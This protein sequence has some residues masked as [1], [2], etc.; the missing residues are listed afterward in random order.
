MAARNKVALTGIERQTADI[1]DQAA[2][3]R[4]IRDFAPSV[5]VN[6]AGYT[7]VDKAE[8]EPELAMR[9][10]AE[11]PAVRRRGVHRGR[12]PAH[13]YFHRLRFR[14]P[15][16][17]PL[18]GGRPGSTSRRLRPQQGRGRRG[19]ARRLLRA[20]HH[21]HRL[22]VRRLW[23]QFLEDDPAAGGASE[24]SSTL[25]PTNTARRPAT[26]DLANAILAAVAAIA[27]GHTVWGTYHFAGAGETT[28]YGFASRIVAAQAEFTGRRPRVN[29]VPTS[30][31]PTAARRPRNSVLDSSRF[32]DVFG[33]RAEPWHS[34]RRSRGRQPFC[35]GRRRHD[36]QGHHS[37]RRAPARACTR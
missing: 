30:A 33:V 29:P 13:P 27:R 25:S 23:L 15:E 31:Y 22:A 2:V 5:V 36:A 16:E 26:A 19:G 1:T 21:P 17:R 34:C 32:A 37:R 10:N 3:A 4:A 35:T 6:A 24:T 8:S 20:H 12:H 9:A 14:R 18:S 11:G 7:A 28:W